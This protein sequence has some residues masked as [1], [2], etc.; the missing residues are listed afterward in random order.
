[1]ATINHSSNV[2]SD[3][4][5]I[6]LRLR[7][8]LVIRVSNYQGEDSWVVKDPIALKYYQLRGP[9]YFASQMLDGETSAVEIR[10]ALEM[11]F[12]E[13]KI[14]TESV[15]MLVNSF[16]KNGLLVSDL[17]G[18]SAPLRQRRNKELKQKATQLLMS[19]MSIRFPGVDPEP[20]LN[21]LYPKVRFLFWRSTNV[22]CLMLMVA[23]VVLVLSNLGEFYSRL[24]EFS[25]FFNVRN[26]LFMGAIMIVTKSIHELGHGL[27]CKHYGGE[28]H[29]IGFMLLVMTPAMYCNTSDSWL[30][31]N[32]WHR[33]AIGAAGMYVETVIAA[34]AT[35]VWWYTHPG[36]LHYLALNTVF[37]CSVSTIIFNLN[38]LLRYDG[39]YMLSD[40]LEIPNLAQ[41]S[42]TS[43]IN[44]LRVAC[45]GMKPIQHRSLPKRRRWAFAAYSVSSFVYRW[46]VMLM[47]FWFLIQIFEPYGLS[48]LAHGMIAMSLVGMVVIPMFKLTKFFLY[49]GRLREVKQIRLLISA[50][51]VVAAFWF[52]FTI[53]VSRHVT[54]SFVLRP[55]DADQVFVVQPGKIQKLLKKPGDSVSKGETI[56]VLENDDLDLEAEQL[57]GALA[58]ENATLATLQSERRTRAGAGGQIA[59]VSVRI[60]EIKRRLEAKSLKRKNLE[61]VAS[62]DGQVIAPPNIAASP[63]DKTLTRLGRWSGTPLDAQN[64]S[65]HFEPA[66][67]FCIV[68]D[69]KQM[70]ATLVV[71]ESDIKLVSAGHEVQLMFDELPGERFTAQVANVSRDSLSELPRELSI[72]NG[73]SVAAEP[74]GDGSESP[75]LTS[76]EVAVPLTNDDSKLLTGFR[77]TAKIKVSELPLG[78]QLVRYLQTVINFR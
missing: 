43:M 35:F 45:L 1:M 16:H 51:L 42:K 41:K 76:Y 49:P 74:R 19:V 33:I 8:D 62:R 48:V 60:A 58:R 14:T 50:A 15:H 71:N 44:W 46:F 17:P 67:L 6:A 59:K 63:S 18:Q 73:G 68:G 24:P 65:A 21:W 78:Q 4:R 28:C 32:K 54:A 69:P 31:P 75:L 40:Y 20:F 55:I 53:P 29:E 52:L 30:L 5:P 9:E 56:A 34:I 13:T 26:I 64:R 66:T 22:V 77:G 72:T 57:K 47:I 12:P 11:E 10:D 36:W 38:P 39:Y 7:P 37:L 2:S 25:Q 70:Q 23:A 61:L 27:T 3:R